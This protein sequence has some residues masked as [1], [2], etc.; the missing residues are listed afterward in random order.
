MIIRKAKKSD[1]S[2]IRNIDNFYKSMNRFIGIDM[3]DPRFKEV[4]EAK[5]YYMNFITGKKKWCYIVEEKDKIVGFILFNIKKREPYYK[6]KK[7]GYI[8]LVFVDS[9]YRGKGV[10]KLLMDKAHEIFMD[11]GIDYMELSV[12]VSNPIAYK[13]WKRHGFKDYRVEMFKKLDK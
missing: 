8:D 5:S 4:K 6:I 7:V 13:A 12:H 2:G 3:L 11:E 9:R 1:E 10:S